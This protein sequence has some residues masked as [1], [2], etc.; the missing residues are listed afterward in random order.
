MELLNPGNFR[1][2]NDHQKEANKVFKETLKNGFKGFYNVKQGQAHGVFA[3]KGMPWEMYIFKDKIRMC[4][5]EA[6]KHTKKGFAD[7]YRIFKAWIVE[8]TYYNYSHLVARYEVRRDLKEVLMT[9]GMLYYIYEDRWYNTKEEI[10]DGIKRYEEYY[11][12]QN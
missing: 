2:L 6:R 5:G 4:Y 9:G 7:A 11:L 3:V 8:D 10:D 1:D 12:K